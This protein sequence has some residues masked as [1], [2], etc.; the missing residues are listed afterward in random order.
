MPAAIPNRIAT[1]IRIN[2]EIYNKTKAI[3]KRESRNTNSQIEYF[4]KKG[5]EA[6]EAEH[7]VISLHD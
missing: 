5:V 7:G 2:E 6:Y 3:A 1:Q 4:I